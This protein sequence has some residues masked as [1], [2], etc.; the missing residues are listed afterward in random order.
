MPVIHQLDENTMSRINHYID[1]VTNENA[2]FINTK[3]VLVDYYR[4]VG[5]YLQTGEYER[6]EPI[7]FTQEM[8]MNLQIASQ[9]NRV[10]YI[11]NEEDDG[12]QTVDI[13]IIEKDGDID[14]NCKTL[15]ILDLNTGSPYEW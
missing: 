7:P 15:I 10:K 11:I 9:D 14:K 3:R 5:N 8:F 4:R 12:A 1:E 6:I 13:V 2:V